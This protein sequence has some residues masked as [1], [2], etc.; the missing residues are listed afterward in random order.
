[1]AGL[2]MEKVD[3]KL[4]PASKLEYPP[5]YEVQEAARAG[6]ESAQRL[7]QIASQQPQQDHGQITPQKVVSSCSSVADDALTNLKKMMSLLGRKGHARV[8][9]SPSKA[10]HNANSSL[11]HT[12]PAASQ[13][14]VPSAP[15]THNYSSSEAKYMI[16][17]ESQE[18]KSVAGMCNRS[19][20]YYQQFLALQLQRPQQQPDFR[21]NH[22]P[23]LK[24]ESSLAGSPTAST[25]SCSL[26][27]SKS[28]LSS[29]SIDYRVADN[30]LSLRQ[31]IICAAQE[32][33]SQA[34]SKTKCCGKCDDLGIKCGSA[35]KCVCTKRRK[36]KSKR[37]IEVP[38]INVKPTDIPSDEFSW[39][40]YGQKP[41]KG[42]PHPRGYYRCSNTRD[43]PA[44]KHVERS[45]R[46]PTMLIVTY[47][48][49]HNHSSS[50]STSGIVVVQ[51]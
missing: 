43:C 51:S 46:D 6:L 37:T 30:K 11:Q 48:G 22:H 26:T 39:R 47:E 44:R 4:L 27:A 9:W 19:N 45:P 14:M 29:P 28:V 25:K 21:S 16:P 34:C 40:K 1:M 36:V 8:R 41:I 32:A 3:Y 50:L 33:G 31:P 2:Y 12:L 38:A 20:E 7:I 10:R 13:V 49:E 5:Y 35:G 18:Q 17:Q 24:L 15:F 23:Y 42:S